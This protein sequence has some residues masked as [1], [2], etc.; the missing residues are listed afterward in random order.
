MIICLNGK[1]VPE[2]QAVVS[3][4][5]RGFL[6][7]DGLFEAIRVSNGRLF[8]WEQHLARLQRGA[9]FL[10][11]RPA[12]S[13]DEMRQFALQLI[14][15]NGLREGVLRIVLSRGVGQRGYSPLGANE[16]T[17]VLSTHPM[18][19]AHQ[20]EMRRW[21]LHTSSYPIHPGDPLSQFKTCNKLVQVLA[22][23]EAE[24]AGADEGLLL[25]PDGMVAEATSG[26]IFWIG[27]ETVMSTPLEKGVLP[28]ITRSLL[29]ELC[30]GLNISKGESLITRDTL[31]RVEG[32]FVSLTT[33]GIVEVS[34]VD[35]QPLATSTLTGRLHQAYTELLL[36]E[37]STSR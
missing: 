26:N 9:E 32:M 19:G 36:A 24:E 13:L 37:T 6:Y 3:V 1:F 8:R 2:E 18:T 30:Q 35:K 14:Q 10:K 16:P 33:W 27:D 12:F 21:Q 5:D 20:N 4:L 15:E 7:G 28:G 23:A 22:R 25:T 34:H 31:K 17:L 11:L 29:F